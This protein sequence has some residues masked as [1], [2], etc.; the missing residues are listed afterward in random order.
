MSAR[1]HELLPHPI[2]RETAFLAY[3]SMQDRSLR[4]LA[5]HLGISEGTIFSWSRSEN[6][7]E[8]IAR[9]ER[10]AT[11][12][13]RRHASLLVTSQIDANIRTAIALRDDVAQHGRTRLAAAQF[14]SS[15]AGIGPDAVI[16]DDRS[17]DP[18]LQPLDMT[19]LSDDDLVAYLR[20][21]RT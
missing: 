20:R 5:E 1:A 17:D 3:W 6:W 10:Q 16:T 11:L 2:D 13:V 8:R 14:L 15:L 9:E 18:D 4:K 12:R 21:R 7:A 19:A